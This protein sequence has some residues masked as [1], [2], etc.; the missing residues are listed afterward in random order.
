MMRNAVQ[1]QAKVT[2]ITIDEVK[3]LMAK[4][5]VIVVDVRDMVAFAN[6]HIPGARNILFDHIPNHIDELQKD[7]RLVVTYCAC[8]EEVTSIRAGE[9]MMAFGL[10][11]VKAMTGGWNEWVKRGEKV[12]KK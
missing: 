4:K 1:S 12:E 10:K 7:G 6:G 8:P 11:N 3:A 5:Q 2:R 9:D